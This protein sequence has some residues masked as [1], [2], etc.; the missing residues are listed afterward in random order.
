[1][2]GKIFVLLLLKKVARSTAWIG[3]GLSG[4]LP[5]EQHSLLSTDAFARE[6]WKTAQSERLLQ[7]SE[8]YAKAI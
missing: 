6:V 1:M 3:G 4:L 2:L 8:W 7:L 5:P